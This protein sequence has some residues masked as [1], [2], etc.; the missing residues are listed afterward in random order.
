MGN[1][2]GYPVVETHRVYRNGHLGS[3]L[4]RLFP[5]ND[6]K[7][8]IARDDGFLG[9]RLQLFHVRKTSG[10]NTG[11]T[12]EIDSKASLSHTSAAAEP[13]QWLSRSLIS[14]DFIPTRILK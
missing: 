9:Q 3:G 6:A 12:R 4:R 11:P 8:G 7:Q 13:I 14:E 10:G 5:R 1:S 2:G